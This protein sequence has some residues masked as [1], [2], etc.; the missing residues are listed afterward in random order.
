MIKGEVKVIVL[1][2]I[3]MNSWAIQNHTRPVEVK[4]GSSV[5][6]DSWGK[7]RTYLKE[8]EYPELGAFRVQSSAYT[9][10]AYLANIHIVGRTVQLRGGE[11]MVRI[12]IDFVNDDEENGSSVKGWAVV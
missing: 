7:S 1:G 8:S 4:V 12:R 9:D 3:A 10:V 11:A 6:V 5:L 2:G